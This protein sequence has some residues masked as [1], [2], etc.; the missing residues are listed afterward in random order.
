MYKMIRSD[1]CLEFGRAVKCLKSILECPESKGNCQKKG[2]K[3]SKKHEIMSNKMHGYPG[4]SKI[5]QKVSEIQGQLSKKDLKMSKMQAIMSRKIHSYPG[6]P[7][8]A[9]ICPETEKNCPEKGPN[10]P[11]C[12]Q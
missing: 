11:K 5:I 3:M 10:C 9:I 4:M 7:E 6:C 8:S 12:K 1:L 2:L